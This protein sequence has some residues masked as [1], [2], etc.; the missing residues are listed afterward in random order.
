MTV[1][2][3]LIL[4]TTYISALLIVNSAQLQDWLRAELKDRTGYEFTAERL[5]LD[6]LLRLTLSGITVSKASKPVLQADRVLVVFS[7][8]SV[9]FKSIYRLQ[10]FGP[11]LHL[12]FSELVDS[13]KTDKLAVSVRH[14]SIA[15]GTVLL[16]I[17]DG[18]PIELRSLA[19]NA[20]DVNV[21]AGTGLNMRAEVPALK[22]FV[23]V[24]V[25]GDE[26]EKKATIRVEQNAARGFTDLLGGRKQSAPSLE[27]S[28]KF[29]NEAGEPFQINAGGKLN[30]MTI[31]ADRFS[32]NFDV[33][34]EF[35]PD[36]QEAAVGAKLVATELPSRPH[37]LAL[38]LPGT[39]TLTLEGNYEVAQKRL[40]IK[41]GKLI[42]PVGTAAGN[43]SIGFAPALMLTNTRVNV[44]KVPVEYLK[45][46]LPGPV[47]ALAFSGEIEADLQL[48]GRWN[49]LE[50]R[51]M[52]WSSGTQVKDHGFS[53]AELDLKTQVAYT[54]R[55]FDAKAVELRGRKVV[56]KRKNQME[57]SAEEIHFDG[58]MAAKPD[59][60]MKVAG[61][62]RIGGGRFASADGSKVGENLIVS[63]H[64]E[65]TGGQKSSAIA[66]SGKLDVEQGEVLW[67]KFFGDLK[68]QRP[69]LEF[70]GGYTN[71]AD[72]VR[73][74]R[75]DLSLA[76][77]GHIAVTGEIERA[78]QTPMLRLAIN[79]GDLQAAGAFELFIRETLNRTYPIL[80]RLLIR[81]G[82]G[83]AVKATGSF[84]E[85]ICEGEIRLR[86]GTIGAKANNWQVAGIALYL[87]L[88]V[89]YPTAP[90]DQ[91]T[92]NTPAG[93][94]TIDSARFG[95]ETILPISATLSLWNNRLQINQPIRLPIYGGSLRISRVSWNDLIGAPRAVS[96][97]IDAENL[98]L[99]KLT[100]ALGWYRF[101]GTLTG[102]IPKIEWT[103]ESL[104]SQGKIDVT[105][106]GGRVQISQLEIENPFSLVPSV[107]LDAGFQDIQ[108]EQ[109]TKT[110][111]FGSISGILEGT[112]SDLVIANRQPSRFKAD[113]HSVEKR[114]FS[115]RISVEALNK[116]TVLSSGTDSGALYSG[117]A[118]FFDNFGYS[119]LGF[120]ATL[121][122]DKLVVRGVE[123]RDGQE[124]LV[125]GTFLPPT[126]NVISH[127]QE[128]AFSEL[129]RRLER[130]Q[131]SEAPHREVR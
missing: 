14:L 1:F 87:P 89:R 36:L 24:A 117:I 20:E 8:V 105:V 109:L 56:V 99:I 31:A 88:R 48:E 85:L 75:V 59:E 106:F 16:K 118:G 64:V 25:S 83:M 44:R 23:E 130:V 103:G 29:T 55:S 126:V 9:F 96:L 114:G 104:R 131:Q 107:K 4:L 76:S 112:V 79:S 127:T 86:N 26:K 100:E 108:L 45:P 70:D 68:S 57:I 37:F 129:V 120:R 35:T 93:V 6:P 40:V 32:G 102:S 90:A 12:D 30:G 41:S 110:F 11:T 73:L 77:V 15:D 66:M 17:G 78:S 5:R 51:G 98:Q 3:V 94:L 80:D 38:A 84:D 116:I 39:A 19:M 10:L 74:R 65:T 22:G 122:N 72:V 101:G 113:I 111:A 69:S 7:P 91:P 62:L 63:G 18:N 82:I 34:A 49:A 128:I 123:S 119:K 27:A 115:Q 53:L 60:A 71:D 52:A 95:T 13:T 125:V 121:K 97:S 2:F 54:D 28:I 50:V 81:G 43:G 124:Y 92:A 42:S 47:Q 61:S 58:T 67:G 33:R 46:L 21:G